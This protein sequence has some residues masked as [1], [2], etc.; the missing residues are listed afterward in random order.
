MTP[1]EYKTRI[2]KRDER[3]RQLRKM[4]EY[5]LRDSDELARHPG[6]YTWGMA[7]Y[8][9]LFFQ[10]FDRDGK[11][12]LGNDLREPE[13]AAWLLTMLNRPYAPATN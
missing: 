12:C 2:E 7:F 8:D 4:M 13:D 6:P 1:D 9:G 10:F 11:P 5:A 3:E